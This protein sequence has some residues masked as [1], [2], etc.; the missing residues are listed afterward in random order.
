MTSDIVERQRV[1]PA[2][3][4]VGTI[5]MA[6]SSMAQARAG[7]VEDFYKSHSITMLVGGGA[8]G[9]YDVYARAFARH[10]T[11]HIP[12]HP[13][14]IPKNLP[15]AAGLAAAST[16]FNGAER[17]GS[18]IGAFT[19][20]AAMDPLF[21]DASAHYDALT[22][23]WLGSIGKLQN[24]CATWHDSTIKTIADARLRDVIVAAAGATSNT[25]IVP[26]MLNALI[27]TRFK[28]VSGYDPSSGLTMAVERGEAE[29]ICGLSWSTIKASRP[30]WIADHLLNVIVQMGL[31]KLHDLP[32]VPSALDLVE[33]PASRQVMEL[34]LM[35]QEAGRPFAAPPGAP[36]DRVAA[37]RRAFQDTLDDKDFIAQADKSQ[38]EIDPMSGDAIAVMLAR[39]YA[40]PKPIVERAAELVYPAAAKAQ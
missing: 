1:R 20:G 31:A 4:I 30:H 25:A 28:V 8:G 6:L 34:I 14:I 36:A 17:D 32:D 12:G 21:G 39:A 37:L 23:N 13:N 3:V 35:R 15:A 16:L 29:G 10:W 24:V 19:N 5:A 11:D 33:S 2:I 22:F 26:N 40:A 27:G 38:L 7:P 18:V 9:G